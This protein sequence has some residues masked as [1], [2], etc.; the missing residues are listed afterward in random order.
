MSQQT[1]KCAHPSCN[2]TVEKGQKYCST[3]C[4]DAGGSMELS[5]NCAH[6]GCAMSEQVAPATGAA[7]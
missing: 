6:A 3:Y 1:K 4:K 5:C 7:S 2:C